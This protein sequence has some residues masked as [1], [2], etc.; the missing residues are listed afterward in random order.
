LNF[1]LA[2]TNAGKANEIEAMFGAGHTVRTLSDVGYTDEIIEDG[3]T[4]A[5]NAM[6]KARAIERFLPS[7][8]YDY[9]LADDSGIMIDALGGKP[10]VH[11]KDWLGTDVPFQEKCLQALEILADVPHD[12]RTAR[13]VCAIACVGGGKVY[14]AEGFL[15][16]HIGREPKGRGGFGYDPIFIVPSENRAL[17]E[18]SR[19]EKNKISHRS[20]AIRKIAELVGVNIK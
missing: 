12:E 15:E 8:S 10:G 17:A 2:T 20:K 1:I 14:E 16:G 11:T 6:L 5:E 3:E 18:L 7:G 9:I 13:F 4:F 19:D